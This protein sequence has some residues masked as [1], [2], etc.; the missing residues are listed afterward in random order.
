MRGPYL[1]KEMLK[2]RTGIVIVFLSGYTEE[3]IS[4][5][6]GITGFTLVEKPYTADALLRSLRRALDGNSSQSTL[7]VQ[8]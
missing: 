8:S 2:H 5:S 3:V 7:R 6:D 1:A 4:Q